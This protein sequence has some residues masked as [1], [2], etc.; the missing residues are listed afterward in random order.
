MVRGWALIG[1]LLMVDLGVSSHILVG[2]VSPDEELQISVN[3]VRLPDSPYLSDSSGN[4][5]F[6]VVADCPC[7]VLVR[8]VSVTRP[9]VFCGEA[10]R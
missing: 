8:A 5:T 2:V 4:L 6:T 7:T 10:P 3:G 9:S 1:L